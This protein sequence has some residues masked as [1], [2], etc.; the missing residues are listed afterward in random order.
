ME[1]EEAAAPDFSWLGKEPLEME[2]VFTDDG[3]GEIPF[4]PIGNERDWELMLS[5]TSDRV[6]SGYE[7]HVFPM[8]D[9]VCSLD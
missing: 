5:S 7:D 6:C 9:R 4:G 2:S 1:N 3:V 8:Y